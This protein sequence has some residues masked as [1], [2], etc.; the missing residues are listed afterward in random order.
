MHNNLKLL[1]QPADQ[2]RA[3]YLLGRAYEVL[4]DLGSWNLHESYY[5]ACLLKDPRGQFAR[6][7][8]D[9]LE[10]SLYMGFSGSAGTHL[11]AEER[12]RLQRLKQ[13]LGAGH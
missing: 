12:D 7:C 13:A 5:E 6:T 1:S 10:A 9:R 4:D 11:P 8:Y 2:A 3:L